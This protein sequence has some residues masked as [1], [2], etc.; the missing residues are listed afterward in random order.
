MS[1]KAEKETTFV[2]SIFITK[3]KTSNTNKY[4]LIE[5]KAGQLDCKIK[6]NVLNEQEV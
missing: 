4:A 5:T 2:F 1:V 6:I 3:K